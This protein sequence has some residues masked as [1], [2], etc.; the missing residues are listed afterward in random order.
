MLVS[1]LGE[2][3]T[4]GRCEMTDLNTEFN[5]FT[6][7]DTSVSTRFNVYIRHSYCPEARVLS[8]SVS[9]VL[10]TETFP[11][12]LYP[13]PAYYLHKIDRILDPELGRT[14]GKISP[15]HLSQ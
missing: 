8:T 7:W 1:F 4:N 3:R 9:P 12:D 15:V 10:A 2:D 11:L 14:E 5:S 13:A 6:S